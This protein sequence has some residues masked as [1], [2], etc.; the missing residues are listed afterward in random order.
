MNRQANG[1]KH[2][3]QTF[4]LINSFVS[5]TEKGN[6]VSKGEIALCR[7]HCLDLNQTN[8]LKLPSGRICRRH[9]PLQMSTGQDPARQPF[10]HSDTRRKV[11]FPFS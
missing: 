3:E 4:H 9:V 5:V 7:T 2:C 10:N 6:H 1:R 11:S 8:G